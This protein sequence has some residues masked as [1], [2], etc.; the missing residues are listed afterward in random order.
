LAW[1]HFL[2]AAPERFSAGGFLYTGEHTFETLF[3]KTNHTNSHAFQDT[4]ATWFLFSGFNDTVRCFMCGGGLKDW[5]FTDDPF[6]E[7]AVWFP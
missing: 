4:H 3:K 7:H 1:P 5:N 2:A 6:T